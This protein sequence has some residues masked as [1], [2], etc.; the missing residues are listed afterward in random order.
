[1]NDIKQSPKK[2]AKQAASAYESNDYTNA[3]NLY[4]TAGRLYQEAGDELMA[5]EMAN[6][7]SVTLLKMNDA[8]GAL[9]VVEGTDVIFQDAGDVNR[10]AIAAANQAAAIE[11]QGRLDE[12]LE[13]YQQASDL[14]KQSGNRQ[15]RSYVL[16][17]ISALQ[18]RTGKQLQAMASMDTALEHKSKLSLKERLLRKLL[19]TQKRLM[20]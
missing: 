5:A 16:Q 1:M 12:A 9:R 15:M 7:L 11:A 18:L 20:K 14:L 19:N 3:A 13:R 6:N 10:Q 4:E 2:L 17:S 8:E